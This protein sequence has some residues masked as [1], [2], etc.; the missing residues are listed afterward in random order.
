MYRFEIFSVFMNSLFV[1]V[2][3]IKTGFWKIDISHG[4]ITLSL[5]LMTALFLLNT[6]GNLLSKNK[7]EKK[8]FTPVT[9]LLTI[10]SLLVALS[11]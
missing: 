9:V 5:W 3:L 7:F 11:G 2:V 10:F 1:A 8:V 4:I 6:I